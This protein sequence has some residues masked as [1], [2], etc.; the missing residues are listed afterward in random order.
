MTGVPFH[1]LPQ[2]LKVNAL[3]TKEHRKSIL[4]NPFPLCYNIEV[5]ANATIVSSRL[6]LKAAWKAPFVSD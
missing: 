3:G 1:Y 5:I 2:R 6:R 4:A